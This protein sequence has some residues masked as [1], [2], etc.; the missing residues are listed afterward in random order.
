MAMPN[1]GD[2][3]L[4]V[5]F[6]LSSIPKA[7]D[8]MQAMLRSQKVIA[9]I[10]YATATLQRDVRQQIK[11]AISALQKE[12]DSNPVKITTEAQTPKDNLPRTRYALYDVSAV[13]TRGSEALLKLGKDAISASAE[14]ESAFSNIE[15]TTMTSI[16]MLDSLDNQLRG[17]A[18][19]IPVAFKDITEIASLGA[20]LGVASGDLAGFAETVAQFSAVT[21]VSTTSAAQSFGALG[22]L[23]NVTANQYVNLGSSIAQV[24]VNSVATESEILSVATAI[25]GVANSAGL[26]ADYVIGLAGSLASLRVPAEQS[27]GA[28]T[29]VFQ[30]I[31]RSAA[32]TG[33]DMAQFAQVMGVSTEE[34]QNLANSNVQVFFD[35]F[36]RGLN[37]L[38]STDLTTTLDNL[39][40]S[41]IRV[42]NV[43]TRLSRNTEL[44][45]K[46]QEDASKAYEDGTFLAA[47]YALKAEDLASKLTILQNSVS[48]LVATFGESILPVVKPIID[49]ISS[50]V[51]G[52]SDAL[53]TEAG[54]G[55]S[56][57]IVGT[58]LMV[59]SLLTVISTVALLVASLYAMRTALAGLGWSVASGGMQG[60]AAS[61]FTA[62]VNART[63]TATLLGTTGAIAGMSRGVAAASL[64]MRALPIIG[65]IATL[66]SLAVAFQ[67]AG[68]S[69]EIAFQNMV[70][71]TAGLADA[72]KADTDAYNAMSSAQERAASGMVPIE[73]SATSLN[74]K[75]GEASQ[76][77]YYTAQVLGKDIPDA[78]YGASS[79][80]EY[81][82]RVLGDNTMAWFNNQLMQSETFQKLAGNS[83]FANF[84]KQTGLDFTEALRLQADEGED[85]TAAYFYRITKAAYDSGKLTIEQIAAIDVS[86]SKAVQDTNSSVANSD[87]SGGATWMNNWYDQ[88][89]AAVVKAIPF[90]GEISNWLKGLF[91]GGPKEFGTVDALQNVTQ[92]AVNAA[93]VMDVLKSSTSS[94][95][96]SMDD[97]S[98]S[99]GG[100]AKKIYLLTDYASDLESIFSRAFDIRFSGQSTMDAVTKSFSDM[101]QSTDDARQ[102][103]KDLNSDIDSLTS[104]KALQEYFLSVAEAYGDTIRAAELRAKIAKIDSDLAQKNKDLAKAQDKTNKTLVGNSDAA[105]QNRSDILNLVKQYQDHIKALAASGMK[106]DELRSTTAQLK[107]DFISQ[108]KQLGFNTSELSTYAVAFDDVQASIDNVARDVTVDFNGDPALTAIEEFVAKANQSLGGIGSGIGSTVTTAVDDAMSGAVASVKSWTGPLA[109]AFG[110]I[111][112]AATVAVNGG[113]LSNDPAVR[114]AAWA[115]II[116]DSAKYSA[117][118]GTQISTT[119]NDSFMKVESSAGILSNNQTTRDTAWTGIN[120]TTT[121]SMDTLES[122]FANG[123]VGAKLP[124]ASFGTEISSDVKRVSPSISNGFNNWAGYGKQKSTEIKDAWNQM[125]G[126]IPASVSGKSA[127]TYNAFNTLGSQ[128]KSGWNLNFEN[129]ASSIG[130]L[131]GLWYSGGYT[132]AGGKYEPAGI[133]H[134]G[135]YVVPK[136]Q[137]NQITQRPYFMESKPQYAAGGFVGAPQQGSQMVYLSPEDR[138]LLRS[139]GGSS[140]VVLYANNEAIARSVNAGNRSIVAAGGRP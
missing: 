111:N 75:Y 17:L 126:E 132:G 50:M 85:A 11:N 28:L 3:Q 115:G 1:A 10:G 24:G 56:A 58:S 99:A 87:A 32:G 120:T 54:K 124:W 88:L 70:G 134:K 130:D 35:K 131:F 45:T 30:E 36:V 18:R 31:S 129:I 127:A 119:M 62:G 12:A 61:L 40:L 95:S 7:I 140:E 136:E 25:G 46:T 48:E 128:A 15:R 76:K 101:S 93:A 26:S 81:N 9:N 139:L 114:N 105:V 39:N 27:R 112:G 21:N 38:N 104:D 51:Q 110:G 121:T 106:Q 100:A 71:N 37:G 33:A 59:G 84:A 89:N 94:T 44:M 49:G 86:L 137:V 103:I 135:E 108:A 55:T 42:T 118:T 16:E 98:G 123:A 80:I 102:S 65:I 29:R 5:S 107:E 138:S 53:T 116:A 4:G 125:A 109:E 82:T 19:D 8:T 52:I 96:D 113:T 92:G 14:Y 60:F 90:L 63:L 20:Q 22:E 47:A 73:Y 122:A 74:A 77:L 83:E 13:A 97:L 57:I 79:A 6:D 68:D 43:L 34:A 78:A 117:T 64:A 72:L 67:Q 133:V 41:D 69:S 91:G 66:A 23:L 2:I